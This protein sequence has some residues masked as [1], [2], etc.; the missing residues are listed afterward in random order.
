MLDCRPLLEGWR[1]LPAAGGL[2]R[3]AQACA[4]VGQHRVAGLIPVF[5]P[6]FDADGLARVVPGQVFRVTLVAHHELPLPEEGALPDPVS[7]LA[8]QHR[9]AAN[10]WHWR[11]VTSAGYRPCGP[12]GSC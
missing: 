9:S 5:D 1:L 3:E 10:P 8:Q 6:P 11:C 7:A 2:A 12:G 4:I